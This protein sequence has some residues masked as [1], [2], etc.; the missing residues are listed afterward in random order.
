MKRLASLLVAGAVA[1]P[2]VLLPGAVGAAQAAGAPTSD[3]VERIV[4]LD[5]AKAAHLAP[6]Q[7]RKAALQAVRADQRA[8]EQSAADAGVD[9]VADKHFVQ[10]VNGL[11]VSVAADDLAALAALP[12]VTGVVEPGVFD[13]PEPV[14]A[15][16]SDALARGLADAAAEGGRETVT[17]TDLTGV[18]EAH[19][20]GYTGAGVTI[21]IIDSGIAWDHPAFGGGT[22]PNKKVVGGYDFADDDPDPYDD[23]NGSAAG[24][25]THVAGIALGSDEHMTGV[26]PDA[27]LRSYR[28]FG[29]TGVEEPT[30]LAALDLAAADGVDVVN[31]SLGDPTQRSSSALA[32]AVNQLSDS[33]VPVVVSNGNGFA[34][35]FASSSPGVAAKAIA[36]G[37]VY[38][39]SNPWLAFTLTGSDI[40]VPYTIANRNAVTPAEGTSPIATVTTGCAPLAPGSLDGK[41]ALFALQFG[42]FT[43]RGMDQARVVK[44]AGAVAA[45]IYSTQISPNDF[46]SSICCGAP[47][48]M[49]IAFIRGADVARISATTQPTLTWGAYSSQP[50]VASQ[51]GLMSYGSSWGPGNELEFKP[52]VSAPGE[53]VFSTVP[54]R[55]G[56]Y[57]QMAGTSMAAPH[58]AGIVALMLQADPGLRPDEIR[59]I[60]ANTATPLGFTGDP[61]R[62]EQP[63]TQ[64]GAGRVNAARALDVIEASAPVATPSRL[65]FGDLEGRQAVRK[66]TV[67]NRGD[68]AVTYTVAHHAA[69]SAQ[70]PYTF[71]WVASDAAGEVRFDRTKL[72]VAAHSRATINVKL[73]EPAGIAEGTLLGG[74]VELTP[75]GGAQATIRVPY[76][77]VAGDLDAVSAINP[78]FTAINTKLDNPALRPSRAYGRNE[79]VTIDLSD[80]DPGNDLAYLY[81]SHGF[82]L[83]ERYRMQVIDA[84]G[85]VVATPLDKSW[86]VRISGAGT[87]LESLT[88]K[89]VDDAGARVAP[90]DY[91]LRLVFDK[92]L[93]DPDHASPT[94]TWTSPIVTVAG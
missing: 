17:V 64:Q 30:L 83:L 84:R 1:L 43:C 92:A 18:P 87:G 8:F 66:I 59:T 13:A 6:G 61:G 32:L 24:H 35:P 46:T 44:A 48:D 62:G 90:G 57:A 93:G 29:S 73:R 2:A 19:D 82:P 47:V 28:V 23:L 79:P 52:D 81:V 63:T 31:M 50:R 36:V 91:R 58:V 27:K 68:T 4:L 55:M 9:L 75:A 11:S 65:A 41:V 14:T 12:G 74:W 60:L 71:S 69:V 22:F 49:P 85:R 94:E 77:A 7:Q 67:E 76:Q 53:F 80:A 10:L 45:L 40:P 51:A 37:N 56:Y 54:G 39:A 16:S 72:T 25:G 70:P 86:V 42:D 15:L 38:T 20:R 26:A 89:G 88:W 34:G 33:G 78:T 21:G 5:P 3:T